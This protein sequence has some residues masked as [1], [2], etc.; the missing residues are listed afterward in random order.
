MIPAALPRHAAPLL[1]AL[2]LL[3][4]PLG[5]QNE[6]VQRPVR[7]PAQSERPAPPANLAV[8]VVSPGVVRLTWEGVAGASAYQIGRLVAPD[9]WR[10]VATVG[11]GTHEYVDEGRDLSKPHSY[12]VVAVVGNL[13]S[14]PARVTLDSAVARAPD[15]AP[16]QAAP[17]DTARCGGYQEPGWVVCESESRRF[18]DRFNGTFTVTARCP[19]GW[20]LVTGGY[21]GGFWR[22]SVTASHPDYGVAGW[23]VGMWVPNPTPEQQRTSFQHSVRAIAVCRPR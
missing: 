17:A 19:R 9:G 20:I 16:T 11:A 23:T 21:Q 5:A 12:Q 6:P 7:Q 1:A 4:S 10:R 14:L 13:A 15:T 18:D 3:A 2:A 22:G 8:S